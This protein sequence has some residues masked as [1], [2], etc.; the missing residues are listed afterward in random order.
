MGWTCTKKWKL[1]S[2][3]QNGEYKEDQQED[4][5]EWDAVRSD[6]EKRLCKPQKKSIKQTNQWIN[7]TTENEGQETT[8][9]QQRMQRRTKAK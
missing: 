7:W 1:T 2:E 5:K 4:E 9:I 8:E 6:K 3:S